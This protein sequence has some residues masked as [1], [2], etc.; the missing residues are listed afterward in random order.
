MDRSAAYQTAKRK[1][2]YGN[3]SW[4]AWKSASGEWHAAR[5]DRDSLR[6]AIEAQGE[7]GERF[8]AFSDGTAFAQSPKLA[9]IRLANVERG[10]G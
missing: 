10:L 5:E 9:A 7:H 4:L 8:F 1:S 3:Q 2:L 6:A